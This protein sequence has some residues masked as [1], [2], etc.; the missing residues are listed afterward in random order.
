MNIHKQELLND[1]E[2]RNNDMS[3]GVK[4]TQVAKKKKT[5]SRS[6]EGVVE[7]GLV[8]LRTGAR[9]PPFEGQK[10][11]GG[12]KANGVKV[13]EIATGL[14]NL[15]SVRQ[16]HHT[17]AYG[18]VSMVKPRLDCLVGVARRF[19]A[20]NQF[21]GTDTATYMLAY[22]W[23]RM[24][25]HNSSTQHAIVSRAKE[26]FASAYFWQELV[27]TFGPACAPHH[28]MKLFD[29]LSGKMA[30]FSTRSI[31]PDRL[32]DAQ[33]AFELHV[34]WHFIEVYSCAASMGSGELR[35]SNAFVTPVN[36]GNGKSESPAGNFAR[37]ISGRKAFAD[38]RVLDL[39]ATVSKAAKKAERRVKLVERHGKDGY[40]V[41]PAI[42]AITSQVK[43]MGVKPTRSRTALNGSNGEHTGSDDVADDNRF[44]V[45][46]EH[47]PKCHGRDWASNWDP[48]PAAPR[49]KLDYDDLWLSFMIG[50]DGPTKYPPVRSPLVSPRP[51]ILARGSKRRLRL[52]ALGPTPI[53][54]E[55]LVSTRAN[56]ARNKMSNKVR[57]RCRL[58]KS[59]IQK[60]MWRRQ[61]VGLVGRLRIM[62]GR[63]ID[64]FREKALSVMNAHSELV[65]ETLFGM[66]LLDRFCG[67]CLPVM[68]QQEV[69]LPMPDIVARPRHAHPDYTPEQLEMADWF[70]DEQS[71]YETSSER[72]DKESFIRTMRTV[73]QSLGPWNCSLVCCLRPASAEDWLGHRDVLDFGAGYVLSTPVLLDNLTSLAVNLFELAGSAYLRG[74]DYARRKYAE[75][76]RE[77]AMVNER[78]FN[79]DLWY[80]RDPG[81]NPVARCLPGRRRRYSI[82]TQA[83]R[84]EPV[85]P[86]CSVDI[87]RTDEERRDDLIPSWL[88]DEEPPARATLLPILG[89][90]GRDR[91]TYADAAKRGKGR[92]FIAPQ[93]KNQGTGGGTKL[94]KDVEAKEEGKEE[95]R[96]ISE[97]ITADEPKP[98]D[99]K[100]IRKQISNSFLCSRPPLFETLHS[101]PINVDRWPRDDFAV[102]DMRGAPFCGLTCVDAA[103]KLDP[104]VKE[105]LGLLTDEQL[106]DIA[107]VTG[108]STMV[109]DW[110][111][112]RGLNLVI[113]RW[114]SV[115]GVRRYRTVVRKMNFPKS[116]WACLEYEGEVGVR[117]GHFKLIVRTV[118][119]VP[120]NEMMFEDMH[121]QLDPREAYAIV[122]NTQEG[123]FK[124][125]EFEPANASK[126]FDLK[127][128]AI[129]FSLWECVNPSGWVEFVR[130]LLL[131]LT[132]YY[133]ASELHVEFGR[134]RFFNETGG[135][136]RSISDKRDGIVEEA[137][138]R[139]VKI[140]VTFQPKGMWLHRCAPWISSVFG[141]TVVLEGLVSEQR[142][143]QMWP[144]IQVAIA[145]GHSVDN[146]LAGYQR[147]RTIND[148]IVVT[149]LHFNTVSTLRYMARAL[150][151]SPVAPMTYRGLVAHNVDNH[152]A[153]V[154]DLEEFEMNQVNGIIGEGRNN[155]VLSGF[156]FS[157]RDGCGNLLWDNEFVPKE[158]AVAPIGVPVFEGGIPL[159][160]GCVSLT[161]EAG[162]LAAWVSR[163]MTKNL[164]SRD[165]ELV[166]EF[167]SF[168]KQFLQKYLDRTEI[169]QNQPDYVQHFRKF[170]AKKRSLAFIEKHVQQK[171]RFDN[172]LMNRKELKVYFRNSAF[173]KFE[174]N[175]KMLGDGTAKVK[176]RLIMTMSD[177]MLMHLCPVTQVMDDWN[178]GPWSEFQIKGE[179]NSGMEKL[180]SYMSDR[181]HCVTD[182]SSYESSL[183]SAIREVE[184]WLFV[185]LMTRAGFT[186]VID[187]FKKHHCQARILW[188]KFGEL[189]GD[190]R[191][192][193]DFITSMGNGVNNVCFNAFC[194]YKKYGTMT[195]FKMLAEGDD[196]ITPEGT[197]DP[198]LLA[199]LGVSFSSSV[200]GCSIGDTDFLRSRWI[201]GKRLINI[202]RAMKV[203]YVA[204]GAGL[205]RSKQMFLLRAAAASLYHMSPGHPVLSAIVNRIG[206]E[207]SGVTSFKGW[208]SFFDSWSLSHKNFSAFPQHVEVD[209]SLRR[210]IAE[211]AVGFPPISVSEQLSLERIIEEDEDMYFGRMLMDYDDIKSFNSTSLGHSIVSEED[212]GLVKVRQILR[213]VNE[214]VRDNPRGSV[215]DYLNTKA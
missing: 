38:F 94:N 160:Y 24:G 166:M 191:C 77:A 95:A 134:A 19:F 109:M 101:E 92:S 84:G 174:N 155:V 164:D 53:K 110:A 168:S 60:F 196:G 205:K 197:T 107:S 158:V 199:R 27:G 2:G 106:S 152:N 162:I 144:D 71:G 15:D 194:W 202:G 23:A 184:N 70:D 167:V 124:S 122:A 192:S 117:V 102:I 113:Y 114:V 30:V 212:S 139:R 32:G 67:S 54:Q 45:F 163:A 3:L 203:F 186:T 214:F 200:S 201:D 140:R 98:V 181:K 44:S 188:T 129:N 165:M 78:L 149:N 112:K 104:D 135:D 33:D 66:G 176:P 137:S 156:E 65:D 86:M 138:Y 178:H 100:E 180:I 74:S 40:Q 28:R 87:P 37:F 16:D 195:G 50:R 170:Y 73:E 142:I 10:N 154:G 4:M 11:L 47:L 82:F 206:R 62:L 22:I 128:C 13:M 42:A 108:T 41:D 136:V 116:K 88:F 72:K 80:T 39:P 61:K 99:P 171:Q 131:F 127:K 123:A 29:N 120:T 96:S 215:E 93:V 177:Y 21:I 126:H 211:G 132:R 189:R 56:S 14:I 81:W 150:R 125:F 49:T 1:T 64:S 85:P 20:K 115:E 193:G 169:R 52:R 159:G 172:G 83:R 179:T 43:K 63:E 133:I 26:L 76:R 161:D 190:T 90:G 148:S 25:V 185:E 75:K 31:P 17:D 143:I 69:P 91:R 105:Y 57:W 48:I 209:R 210:Y 36:L 198:E 173:V 9:K 119:P 51:S 79:D 207:T 175:C 6:D 68:P 151:V 153:Y 8:K 97:S 204:K 58:I 208:S 121:V 157:E 111:A 59:D 103:A 182:Y 145:Q 141:D 34:P 147:Y 213:G 183:D 130:N 18:R 146:C 46:G 55:E 89:M 187:D 12:I 118:A 5:K 35:S 7:Q